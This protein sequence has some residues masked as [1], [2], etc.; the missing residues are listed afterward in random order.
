[1][2]VR[3]L[4]W[5]ELSGAHRRWV[6]L[7][8]VVIT[9][10]INAGLNAAIAWMSVRNQHSVPAW[11]LPL[12]GKVS[13]VVDTV[14]TMFFLPLITTLLCTTAVWRELRAGRFGRL[15]A[16][17]SHAVHRLPVGRLR[18]GLV[19]GALCLLGAPLIVVVLVAVDGVS[20]TAFVLYKAAFAV[21][22]GAV[23]TPVIAVRAMAD[24]VLAGRRVIT[25]TH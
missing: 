5:R 1:M 17:S 8:A 25:P 9:A 13:T 23:V 19:L 20:N 11:G 2:R 3:L 24:D 15:D 16:G 18:R 6:L 10:L 14:G 22:L 7:N 4:P 21:A 12:V